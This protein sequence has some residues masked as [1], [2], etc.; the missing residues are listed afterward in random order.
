MIADKSRRDILVFAM[1]VVRSVV[2]G[3]LT[4]LVVNAAYVRT[5]SMVR[6][7]T[8]MRHSDCAFVP[9]AAQPPEEAGNPVASTLPG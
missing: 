4:A 5:K 7:G 1:S 6:S 3:T 9:H 8:Q 2:L